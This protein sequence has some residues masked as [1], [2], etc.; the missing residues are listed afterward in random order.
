MYRLV[1][2]IIALEDVYYNSDY[3]ITTRLKAKEFLLPILS[4]ERLFLPYKSI[5][6]LIYDFERQVPP[7]NIPFC[8]PG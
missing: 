4:G 6:L 2:E 8:N 3:H 7:S 5:A 1:N